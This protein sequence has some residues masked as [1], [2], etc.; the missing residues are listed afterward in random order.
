MRRLGI[1]VFY[2][3]A[4]RVSPHV[5]TT[6]RAFAPHLDTLV[7]VANG[8]LD[9]QSYAAVAPL[10]TH[11]VIRQNTGHD[12]WGYKDGLAHIADAALGSYDEIVLFN[13]TFFTAPDRVAAMFDT[14]AARDLD[15]WGI[16]EYRDT[17]KAYLQSYFL[18][19]RPRLHGS[20][21]YRDYWGTMPPVHTIAD[22]QDHH[23]ARFT[24]HFRALGFRGAAYIAND[25]GWDGNTTL[26][27]LPGLHARGMPVVK[28]RAFTF[29][30]NA[31]QRRGGD[32]PAAN[33][34]Y[35]AA[36]GSYA[37]P[38][39][40]DYLIAQTPPD[41][42]IRNANLLRVLPPDPEAGGHPAALRDV[43]FVV[44]LE[45]ES[46]LAIALD[47]LRSLPPDLSPDR[48]LIATS[49]P[50]I[51]QI[52]RA[53][54][55]TCRHTDAP[56]LA[57]TALSDAVQDDPVAFGMTADT[58]IICLSDF[59]SER[60]RY[61]F[62]R[63]LFDAY[64]GLFTGQGSCLAAITDWLAHARHMGPNPGPELG[65]IMPPP[66]AVDGREGF[67][68]GLS[69][70][71]QN[72]AFDAY[73]DWLAPAQGQ[74]LWPWRGICALRGS[75]L[76]DP[77]F[78]TRLTLLARTVR[79]RDREVFC[80]PEGGLPQLVRASGLASAVALPAAMAPALILRAGLVEQQAHA[81]LQGAVRQFRTEVAELLTAATTARHT[82]FDLEEAD[83]ATRI[84]KRGDPAEERLV[85]TGD[86]R[87]PVSLRP[88]PFV[89]HAVDNV[90]LD[91]NRLQVRGW[92]FDQAKP[93]NPLF[94]G[95]LSGGILT[96]PLRAVIEQRD[97]V[98]AAF[99]N[100]RI[101]S[102]SGFDL[103]CT[104]PPTAL[105]KSEILL[106]VIDLACSQ[107][108]LIPLTVPGR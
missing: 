26:L 60:G 14:M 17:E 39:I 1:F 97:D 100:N 79:H 59:A 34:D 54:G 27:D 2:D 20:A 51:A 107:A 47:R 5:A 32:S 62:K 106:C 10:V 68:H 31:L 101:R 38:E 36:T 35:I 42:L 48:V 86:G 65:L 29:A 80:G 4:G 7:F 105:R 33:L 78:M 30:A 21:A 74:V 82:L 6:L 41:D 11:R 94:C 61:G 55:F 43:R 102:E 56:G 91:G 83:I 8:T 63:H 22:A 89:R 3:A 99:A 104:L 76:C 37:M 46:T 88:T 25:D 81:R 9:A 87:A 85:L 19:T 84:V 64:W 96:G 12:V 16:T 75:L 93:E 92:A 50:A 18:V 66:D 49:Q 24:P 71:R 95:I 53:A 69:Q 40:W 73:P 70:H 58:T 98:R 44:A 28:Y 13:H 15:F 72:W 77:L 103:T 90:V 108:A 23:E 67:I 57:L 52:M 45:D